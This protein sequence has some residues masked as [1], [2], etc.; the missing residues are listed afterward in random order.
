MGLRQIEVSNKAG[1]RYLERKVWEG[2]RGGKK[3]GREEE[4]EEKLEAQLE[5]KLVQTRD[6]KE[7]YLLEEEEAK[8]KRRW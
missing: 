2:G 7:L 5:S 8:N 1:L 3:G 6:L 4:R